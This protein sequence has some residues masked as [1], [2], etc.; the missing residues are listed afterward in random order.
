[1][2][3]RAGAGGRAGGRVD[4][5]TCGVCAVS[6]RWREDADLLTGHCS[7][8]DAVEALENGQTALATAVMI[9]KCLRDVVEA[10][11]EGENCSRTMKA[12]F[13]RQRRDFSFADTA[14]LPTAYSL[15]AYDLESSD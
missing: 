13:A 10:R 9:W 1:M 8:N 4:V 7:R 5:E 11:R 2:I 6:M 15:R 3:S 14:I 12:Q